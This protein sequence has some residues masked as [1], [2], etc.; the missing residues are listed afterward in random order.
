VRNAWKADASQR[1]GLPGEVELSRLEGLSERFEIFFSEDDRERP[2][3]EEEAALRSDPLSL[4][5]ECAARHETMDVQMLTEILPPGMEHH[6]V[7]DL[8]S[9]PFAISTE[10]LQGIRGCL[11]QEPVEHAWISLGE[12]MISWGRVK[13]RWK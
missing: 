8:A 12:R 6:R 10:R 11:E 5:T 13:T 7:P 1:R 3:R 4:G 2:H 9:E